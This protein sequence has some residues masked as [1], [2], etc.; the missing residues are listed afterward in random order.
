MDIKL[1]YTPRTRA[2]RVRWL[3][4]E[5]GTPYQLI[6]I[7]LYGGEGNS[8]AYRAIHPMG[9]VPAITIDGKPMHESGAICAWLTEQF[10]DKQ[11]APQPGTDN[12]RDYQQWMYFIPATLEPPLFYYLL[13]K[14]ILPENQRIPEILPW[15]LKRYRQ[16]LAMLEKEIQNKTFLVGNSFTTADI[17][18]GSTLAWTPEVFS[19]YPALTRYTR[20]LTERPAYKAAIAD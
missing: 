8:E 19:H 10:P 20:Q 14:T 3:L 1:Y 16:V 15:C 5:L 4:E 13:H 2:T 17:M 12:W 7:D 9:Y 6:P 11:L 18:L